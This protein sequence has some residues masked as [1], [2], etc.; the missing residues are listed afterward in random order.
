MLSRT[1]AFT[2]KLPSPNKFA[3]VYTLD[4]SG[5]SARIT[6]GSDATSPYDSADADFSSDGQY[7]VFDSTR[8]TGLNSEIYKVKLTDLAHVTRLTTTIGNEDCSWNRRNGQIV[9]SSERTGLFGTFTMASDGSSQIELFPGNQREILFPKWN[10]AGDKIVCV[11]VFT[12]SDTRIFW[13]D[14]S[15][16][17]KHYLTSGYQD[18]TPAFSPQL[19]PS[20]AI[21]IVFS[22]GEVV[23]GAVDKRDLYTVNLD[24][25]GITNLTNAVAGTYF[26][27]PCWSPDGLFIIFSKKIGPATH[28]IYEMELA[29]GAITQITNDAVYDHFAPVYAP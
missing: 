11:E 9:F 16:L 2:K 26:E 18:R 5:S 20:N 8:N 13:V 12:R 1:I 25:T 19:A 6:N 4:P 28:Q 7:L 24:E 3:D 27:W 23:N 15:G 17:T 22:R 21:K 29:N 14:T 10:S